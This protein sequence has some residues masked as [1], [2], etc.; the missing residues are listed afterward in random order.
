MSFIKIGENLVNV[1]NITYISE[2]E[3]NE[4]QSVIYF[5]GGDKLKLPKTLL[6]SVSYELEKGLLQ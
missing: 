3:L 5:I 6:S 4:N 2:D 1:K